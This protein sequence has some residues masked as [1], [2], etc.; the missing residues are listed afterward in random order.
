[1]RAEAGTSKRH[2][3]L[4]QVLEV[5]VE[6]GY[7]GT[8]T[9]QL[10]AAASASKQTFYKEFGDKEGVFTALIAYAC[11][12]VDDPFVP[13]VERMETVETAEQGVELLAAQM[14]RSIMTPYVQQLRRLVIAEA[15]RFPQ[16]GRM[17][18]ENGF[19][20]LLG[21]ITRCLEV[22]GRRGLL[23][24]EDPRVAA[25][26]LSGLLLWIPG[27]RSMLLAGE[28]PDEAEAA[29]IVGAGTAAFLRAYRPDGT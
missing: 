22:L 26:H 7:V 13:L 6:N 24:V 25:H 23:A 17:F 27:N 11:D 28:L 3:I 21:S 16:L 12:R 10:A 14:L 2:R 9:D 5:F 1:M 4:E 18:W 20:R 19:Q 29:E 15:V 8:T